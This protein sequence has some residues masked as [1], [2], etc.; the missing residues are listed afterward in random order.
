MKPSNSTTCGTKFK[1]IVV[2]SPPTTGSTSNVTPVLRVSQSCGV[3]GVTT[4]GTTCEP[5]VVVVPIGGTCGRVYVLGY[6]N[7]LTT[8]MIAGGPLLVVPLG[9]DRRST[10][11]F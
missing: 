2:E 11:F 1:S 10:P 3:V 8:S 6:R 7:S 5:V 4:T 9:A